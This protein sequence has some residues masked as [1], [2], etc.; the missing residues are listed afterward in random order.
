MSANRPIKILALFTG[1]TIG[2][3]RGARG[4]DVDAAGSY[5]LLEQYAQ[6][7]GTR[8][9]DFETAQPCN[10]L[11]ENLVPG[12]WTMLAKAVRAAYG[13]GY[14]GVIVTHGS[15]TL[16]FSAAMLAYLCSDA[17]I[18]VVLTAANY[19][20][21]DPR[22]NG[23]ANFSASVDFIAEAGLPGVFALFGNDLG[24]SVV[25]L[26]TRITQALPFT[27]QFDAPYGAPFGRM[28]S[29]RFEPNPHPVNPAAAELFRPALPAPPAP[30]ANDE[31]WPP[32]LYVKPYPGLDYRVYDFDSRRPRAVLHDTYHSGT[33]N[34]RDGAEGR[35]LV[36]FISYCRARGVDVYLVPM[37]SPEGDMYASSSHLTEAGG[38][39]LGHIS[40]EAALMKLLLGCAIYED[41]REVEQFVRTPLFFEYM[42]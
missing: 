27:D 19:P 39:A 11:S 23:L 41:A 21:E 3:R 13:G 16:S 9:I 7:A 5:F 2:S 36:S 33:A 4:I 32:V 40:S 29:G 14:A 38:I 28:R 37:R 10:L 26:G 42:V 1:G 25:Y 22:S 34:A 6:I 24:E 15:D 30:P 35:T 20:L 31:A 8:E 18:P 17:P 12:D